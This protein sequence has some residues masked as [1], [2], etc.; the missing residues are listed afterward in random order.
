[1]WWPLPLL[2]GGLQSTSG[3]AA[4]CEDFATIL[5]IPAVEDGFFRDTGG[6]WQWQSTENLKAYQTEDWDATHRFNFNRVTLLK[7]GR[8]AELA[9]SEDGELASTICQAS[10]RTYK[11]W[12]GATHDWS[13]GTRAAFKTPSVKLEAWTSRRCVLRGPTLRCSRTSIE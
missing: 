9:R 12:D 5:P 7:F 8:P 4:A 13:W 11:T 3:D 2:V 1:M 10:L 6:G